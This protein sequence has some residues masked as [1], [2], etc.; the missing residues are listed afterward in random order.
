MGTWNIHIESILN[1]N[2]DWKR[3]DGQPCIF[4][5]IGDT[6][7]TLCHHDNSIH[8]DYISVYVDNYKS[9]E[10]NNRKR[11]KKGTPFYEDLKG[12]YYKNRDLNVYA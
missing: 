7:V 11:I 6:G 1:S 5:R 10:L 4:T 9:K 3:H 2:S 12:V 8:G